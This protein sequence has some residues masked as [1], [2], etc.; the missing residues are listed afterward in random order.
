MHSHVFKKLADQLNA[1]PNAFPATESRVELKLLE[2]IFSPEEAALASVMRMTH[3]SSETIAQ[4]AEIQAERTLEMLKGMWKRGLVTGRKHEGEFTFAL[5]PFIVG[6]YEAQLPNLDEELAQLVEDYYQASEEGFLKAEP[7]MHRV[8]PV[9]EAIQVDLEVFAFEQA[10]E[11]LNNSKSWAVRDC[12]CRVQQKLVGKGC[13]H[14]INNCLVFAPV[15]GA[16]DRSEINRAIAKEE[17]FE[18]LHQTEEEGLVHSTGNYSSGNMYICNC[19]SCCC[20]ILRG[21][22]EF[23]IPTAAAHSNFYAVVDEGLCIGCEDCVD[24]CHFKAISVSDLLAE[25]DYGR[26]LGCGT[27]AVVCTSDALSL[28]RRPEEDIVMV[29]ATSD[30]WED[31][32]LRSRG[33]S[34]SSVL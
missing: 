27:C 3:E 4:R 29:P 12:I 10:T 5:E 7:S 32:R 23:S 17:A 11:M 31:Q 18:I 14:S 28:E 1:L 21:I 6:F 24:R 9:G 20:G 2:K 15:E 19:C 16:F 26:C 34:N 22:S 33:L 30:D 25:V 8:I 13:D